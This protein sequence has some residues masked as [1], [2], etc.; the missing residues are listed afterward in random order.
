MASKQKQEGMS[1]T[2]TVVVLLIG[3]TMAAA[4][5]GG[6]F[7]GIG[8]GSTG[9]DDPDKYSYRYECHFSD[10]YGGAE[11]ESWEGSGRHHP[12]A[13]TDP[14]GVLIRSSG[15]QP[16]GRGLHVKARALTP[17]VPLPAGAKPHLDCK[18][19]RVTLKT[20]AEKTIRQNSI[21]SRNV[22]LQLDARA[23]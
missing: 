14:F 1:L 17:V 9:T 4:A 3:I 8:G 20:Q 6:A 11:M 7:K 2:A 21:K 18:I 12:T 15:P 13:S 22:W 10:F 16:T 19:V 5:A 23:S